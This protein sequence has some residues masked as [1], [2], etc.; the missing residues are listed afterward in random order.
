MGRPILPPSANQTDSSGSLDRLL[1]LLSDLT[2]TKVYSAGV[3]D[4]GLCY[5]RA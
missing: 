4:G 1:R 5:S 3:A 2:T